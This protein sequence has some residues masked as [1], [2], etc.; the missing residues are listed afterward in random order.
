[1]RQEDGKFEA[2][3]GKDRKTLSEKQSENKRARGVAPVVEFLPCMCNALG[4]ISN[5]TKKYTWVQI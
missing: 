1:V 5:T 3:L 4:L 2:I